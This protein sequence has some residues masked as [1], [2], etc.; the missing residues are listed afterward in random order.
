MYRKVKSGCVAGVVPIIVFIMA[1]ALFGAPKGA[2]KR[3]SDVVVSTG[4]EVSGLLGILLERIGGY[5]MKGGKLE[6]VPF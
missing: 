5:A 4:S 1:A 6:V 3:M 2:A